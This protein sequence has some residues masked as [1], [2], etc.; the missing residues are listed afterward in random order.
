MS[1]GNIMSNG[2]RV[3]Q[4]VL[5]GLTLT[6]IIALSLIARC[7]A[8]G[9]I[10]F[11]NLA[12]N[13]PF[14]G[15]KSGGLVFLYGSSGWGLLN[16]DVNFELE[17][18]P[19]GA[20]SSMQ[21][22]H[23]WLISDGSAKGIAVGGGHF[24]DPSGGTYVIQGVP[25]GYNALIDIYAWEGNFGNYMDA[26][27]A[28]EPNGFVTF[29]NRTGGAGTPASLVNMPAFGLSVIPEPASL[30]LFLAGAGALLLWHRR[31]V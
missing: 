2:R 4:C 6:A 30:A 20:I 24:A 9:T 22:I 23:T 19:N 11:N 8:Q 14:I 13:D 29:Y 17:A 27:A 3:S 15:A 5:K 26:V 7:Q 16:E 10:A 28:G 21:P 12:N 18:G 25:V 1:C 31:R